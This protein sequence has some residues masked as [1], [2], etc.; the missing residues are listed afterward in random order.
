LNRAPAY[1]AADN[2]ESAKI[3]LYAAPDH[4]DVQFRM[5]MS[6]SGVPHDAYRYL[7]GQPR[8]DQEKYLAEETG[9]SVIEWQELTIACADHA[10]GTRINTVFTAGGY[11]ARAGK[12]LFVPLFK[13][14]PFK[15]SLAENKERQRALEITDAYS[16]ADTV[17]LHWP[18]GYSIESSPKEI[19]MK[20][21]F[22][23][24]SLK[25]EKAADHLTLIR[26]F[27]VLPVSV[28]AA[29]YNEVRQFYMQMAKAD[30]A[31]AVLVQP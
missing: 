29:Q 25:V 16:Y 30:L 3:D 26:H 15:H 23:S 2:V 6:V 27:S 18:P 22:G 11:G 8:K 4:Q 20:S 9:L 7:S 19:E 17:T 28:P 13:A 1:G 12:R 14:H 31:Q 21:T 24:Y 5:D 10:P